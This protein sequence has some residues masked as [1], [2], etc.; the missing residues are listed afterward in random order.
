MI[1]NKKDI[2]P[3]HPCWIEEYAMASGLLLPTDGKP[4]TF[5]G[6]VAMLESDR[7]IHLQREYPKNLINLRK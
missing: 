2:Y 3:V 6:N 1:T 4:F 7:T 5:N